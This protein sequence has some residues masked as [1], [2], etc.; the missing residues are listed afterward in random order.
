MLAL[1]LDK[2]VAGAIVLDLGSNAG[3]WP[4]TYLEWGAKRVVC[5][6]GREE[7][8]PVLAELGLEYE[9]RDIRD[10]RIT[11]PVFDIL[12]ALGLVYHLARP[13]DLLRRLYDESGA[14]LMVVES[15]LWPFCWIHQEKAENGTMALEDGDIPRGTRDACMEAARAAGFELLSEVSGISWGRQTLV[16]GGQPV[17]HAWSTRALW[18]MHRSHTDGPWTHVPG[19]GGSHENQDGQ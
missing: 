10:F 4:K 12:S 11:H 5:V 13:W 8:R 3:H 1:R 18:L 17:C 6:E 9:I 19:L 7:F 15:Q 2:T 14:Q 16:L